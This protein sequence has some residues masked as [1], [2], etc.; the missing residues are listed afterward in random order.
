MKP[1]APVS[2]MRMPYPSN[3]NARTGDAHASSIFMQA[4][5]LATRFLH[6]IQIDERR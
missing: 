2:K 1:F 3:H 4:R 6:L 5:S